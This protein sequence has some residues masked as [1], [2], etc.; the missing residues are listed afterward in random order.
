MPD[1]RHYPHVV[2]PR[3]VVTVASPQRRADPELA[4][5]KNERYAEG[6]RRH[7]GEPFL[8]DAS[9]SADV[10]ERAFAMMDGLL[11]SGG[12]DIHPAR[13]GEP[14]L[15]SREI[16]PDRDELEAA[17][18]DAAERRG[19]PVLGICRGFQAINVFAGGSLLQDVPGHEGPGW[20]TGA[21]AMHLVRVEPESRLGALLPAAA[22]VNTYHHQAV[23]PQDVASSL[24]ASAWAESP[25]GEV[26]EAVEGR[27]DRFVVGVQCHPERTEF[28]PPEFER[29]WS[30]F[31]NACRESVAGKPTR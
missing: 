22:N 6:V 24:I 21:A 2:T 17:A 1:D 26:V 29:L 3:I 31:V 4:I 18:W 14:I 27:D 30:A 20:G 13:Y 28:S 8:L 16:E 12:A 23:R 9:A 5:R 10:R 11:L 7:G 25:I 19:V 15:G